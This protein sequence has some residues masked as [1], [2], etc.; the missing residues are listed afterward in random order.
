MSW[1][2]TARTALYCSISAMAV[3]SNVLLLLTATCG[4]AI[5]GPTLPLALNLA[6]CD[7]SLGIMC[8]SMATVSGTSSST[9]SITTTTTTGTAATAAAITT[10]GVDVV[11]G[12]RPPA[13]WWPGPLWLCHA[14]AF[15]QT[16]LQLA[17]LHS[18]LW[19][20]ACRFAEVQRP[21]SYARTVTARRAGAA[22]ALAWGLGLAAAAAPLAGLGSYGPSRATG[23]CGPRFLR[24][25]GGAAGER[26]LCVLLLGL[27]V[28]APVAALAAMYAYIVQVARRQARRG[29]FVCTEA[30]CYYVPA[31]RFLR[32]TVVLVSTVVVLLVCWVPYLSVSFYAAFARLPVH[33]TAEALCSALTLLTSALN[34]WVNFLSQQK[35][36]RALS[37]GWSRLWG[38]ACWFWALAP[39]RQNRRE[40]RPP[41]GGGAQGPPSPSVPRSILGL[42]PVRPLVGNGRIR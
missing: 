38:S 42:V 24:A 30:H 2:P 26:A 39:P 14:R 13:K 19:L 34:P 10:G 20:S 17:S 15:F 12:N 8:A 27:G 36:R 22:V 31:R 37:L 16:S 7:L 41:W 21:L 28:A 35:F 1:L 32:C 6:L 5:P 11:V 33:V 40:V 23:T 29:A 3:P 4:R 9:T 25:E 18:L